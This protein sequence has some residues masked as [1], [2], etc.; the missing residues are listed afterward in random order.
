MITD[1][2]ELGHK[3]CGAEMFQDMNEVLAGSVSLCYTAAVP[4]QGAS[5]SQPNPL[6]DRV[7][8]HLAHVQYTHTHKKLIYAH[9]PLKS[10]TD[11]QTHMLTITHPF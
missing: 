10:L 8:T 9:M 5:P 4:S 2:A 6:C 7:L 11:R 1:G 3:Y